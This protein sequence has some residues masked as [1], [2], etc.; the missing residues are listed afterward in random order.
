MTKY[1]EDGIEITEERAI[2]ICTKEGVGLYKIKNK[3][4]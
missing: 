1:F 3:K 4:K 2:K